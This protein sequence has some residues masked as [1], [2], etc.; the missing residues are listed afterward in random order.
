MNAQ[1]FPPGWNENRVRKVLEYYE[2]QSDGEAAAE[3]EAASETTT[4]EVPVG[5]LPAVR[6]LIA[7]RNASRTKKTDNTS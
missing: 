3:I 1:K 6:Q 4:V 2:S 5:L 7:R